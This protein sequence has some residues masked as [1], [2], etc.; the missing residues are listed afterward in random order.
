MTTLAENA[1]LT[2][3]DTLKEVIDC[4]TEHISIET[5]G[6]FNQ[7]DLFNILIGAASNT[8]SIEN[9]ASK[10]KK[11]CSGKNIRYHLAKFK[12]FQQLEN[13]LNLTLISR[14]PRRI[15]KRK[16]KLAIDFNLIPSAWS[17]NQRRAGLYLS[18]SG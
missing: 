7:T 2:D 16:L 6:A 18:Q 3:K 9:T 11:S 17:T 4:L 1:V 13:Q 14:L 15:K 12:S 5:Q 8:D 10:F